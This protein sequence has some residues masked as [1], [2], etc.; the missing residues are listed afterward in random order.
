MPQITIKEFYESNKRSLKLDLL[1]SKDGLEEKKISQIELHRPGL[2]LTGFVDIFSYERIQIL[3]NTEVAYLDSLS[4]RERN[5]AFNRL[6]EFEIPCI[7]VTN[8]NKVYKELHELCS[9]GRIPL[10]RS[11]LSTTSFVHILGNYLEEEFAPRTQVHATLVDVYGIGVLL[12]GRSGIGKS[13]VGLDLVERGHRLVADDLVTIIR[14]ADDI[15]IGMANEILEHHIEIRGL[16][17]IDVKSIFGIRAIRQQ[18]RVEVEVR[19]EEWD[20]DEDYERV[21]LADNYTEVLEVKIPQVRLP[22]FPGKNITVIIETIALN[23]LLKIFGVH[24]AKEFN[25][26]LLKRMGQQKRVKEYDKLKQYLEHD[27][28]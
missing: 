20:S 12:S 22:I 15:L 19:L 1:S 28:E 17:I 24:P 9:D 13:E 26:K 10:F 8:N 23:T 2:A 25:K 7:V 14:K 21:G 5:I 6:S 18:K 4:T 16:G 11:P 27:T 3:G